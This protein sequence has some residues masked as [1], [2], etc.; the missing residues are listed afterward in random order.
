MTIGEFNVSEMKIREVF[1]VCAMMGHFACDS[2]LDVKLV[3]NW[4]V[5]AANALIDELNVEDS[6]TREW[7]L[8][9][10]NKKR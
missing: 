8:K 6:E 4:S 9:M 5:S 1:A 7:K 3:A 2:D 10:K